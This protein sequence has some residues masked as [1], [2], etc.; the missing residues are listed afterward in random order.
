MTTRNLRTLVAGLPLVALA[1]GFALLCMIDGCGSLAT[2]STD[3]ASADRETAL[4]RSKAENL[5]VIVIDDLGNNGLSIANGDASIPTPNLDAFAHSGMRFTRHYGGVVCSPARAA[6]LTGLHSSRMGF[7][8]NSRGISPDVTTFPELLADQGYTTHFIGK[9]HA[10]D[11]DRE[12]WPDHQGFQHWFGFLNQAELAGPL[13]AG[14]EVV[15]QRPRYSN[16][17]L[18]DNG[19][20]G[21]HH[22]GHLNDILT[23]RT[24]TTLGALSGEPRPWLLYLAFYAPHAPIKPAARFAKLYPGNPEGRY[25][26]LLHQLDDNIG[27]ILT[28]LKTTGA[29][30]NT[31]VAIVSDNGGDTRYFSDANLPLHG[32]K[33]SL[34]EGGLRTPLL[35]RWPE[36]HLQS[37]VVD[38][39]ISIEDIFPT[40]VD[41]LGLTPPPGIDGKSY[42]GYL[43][44]NQPVPARNRFWEVGTN[45]QS[46]SVL[47]ADGRWRLLQPFPYFGRVRDSMLFDL[48]NDPTGAVSAENHDVERS[49]HNAFLR[50]YQDVHTLKTRSDTLSS[51]ELSLTGSDFQRTPGVGGFTF[52]AALHD[53][54]EG[55]IVD[56][57]AVWQMSRTPDTVSVSVGDAKLSGNLNRSKGCQSVIF[58]G[59]FK[60]EVLNFNKMPWMSLSLHIDGILSDSLRSDGVVG[61]K[62]TSVATR[63]VPQSRWLDREK[64]V[65]FNTELTENSPL[66]LTDLDQYLCRS[67]ALPQETR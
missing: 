62:S 24:I 18:R 25:R 46:F 13:E 39:V 51:G 42:F 44:G 10:G 56:Q 17:Y 41:S 64:T 50:W 15:P 45:S 3:T 61:Y 38:D 32:T 48:Q 63:I 9:W 31:V 26:A 35:I 19:E 5:L 11:A 37:R 34:T 6:L 1:A 30:D 60:P 27:R 7:Q 2:D 20:A 43:A 67:R 21:R 53:T 59:T 28:E 36:S 40:L 54:W 23:E 58:S 8:P 22:E 66:T 33:G 65:F 57:E 29:I 52:G 16:P 49:L 12:A 4:S 47:S 55:K 14:A